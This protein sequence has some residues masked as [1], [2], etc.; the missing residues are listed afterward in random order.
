M[1]KKVMIVIVVVLA[2]AAFAGAFLLSRHLNMRPAEATA[3]PSRDAL[4]AEG[5]AALEV[6]RVEEKQLFELIREVRQKVHDCQKRQEELDEQDRRLQVTR[7]LIERESQ[8]LENL[9]VQVAASVARLKEAQAD[10]EKTRTAIAKDEEVNLRRVATVYD[11]MDAL[12]A[13]HILEG[14]CAN[15]QEG[16]AAK[17]LH[18]MSERPVAKVLAEFTDKNAAAKLCD[19]LKRIKG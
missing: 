15:K 18:F 17:I 14:M 4:A 6:P 12:A 10:I 19:Q 3:A 7:Q 11:K 1:S 13:A 5:A 9:R 2:G 8:D 16:D